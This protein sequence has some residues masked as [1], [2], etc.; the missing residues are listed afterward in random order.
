MAVKNNKTYP[1]CFKNN[2]IKR[3][4]RNGINRYYC[5]ECSSWFSSK[6]EEMVNL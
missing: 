6:R 5:N 2:T 4:S 1:N 3:G